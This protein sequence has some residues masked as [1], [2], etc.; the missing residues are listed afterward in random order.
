M[1]SHFSAPPHPPKKIGRIVQTKFTIH[2][3]VP[4]SVLRTGEKV[5]IVKSGN[6]MKSRPTAPD[7]SITTVMFKDKTR[8]TY[9]TTNIVIE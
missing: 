7:V 2:Q 5:Y 6:M 1:G 3:E 4:D 9:P 8:E